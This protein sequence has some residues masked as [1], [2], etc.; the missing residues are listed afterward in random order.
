MGETW[1]LVL[2]GDRWETCGRVILLPACTDALLCV[3]RFSVNSSFKRPQSPCSQSHG[4]HTHLVWVC[5]SGRAPGCTPGGPAPSP[6]RGWSDWPACPDT[7]SQT[8]R[9]PP[10]WSE[11]PGR[12][13]GPSIRQRS[14]SGSQTHRRINES[15]TDKPKK[16]NSTNNYWFYLYSLFPF[17]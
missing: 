7:R 2:K 6:G 11:P 13:R 14:M 17:M 3:Y 10:R 9:P 16:H 1:P 15:D 12:Q 5:L 4:L 8:P